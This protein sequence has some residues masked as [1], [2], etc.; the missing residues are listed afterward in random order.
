LGNIQ[1]EIISEIV[2]E[3]KIEKKKRGRP[4]RRPSNKF[5]ENRQKEITKYQLRNRSIKE[6]KKKN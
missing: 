4:R 5:L 2:Q 1:K 6:S 3:E